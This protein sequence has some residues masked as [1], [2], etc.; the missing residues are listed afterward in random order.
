MGVGET[1]LTNHVRLTCVNEF[2]GMRC[3]TE[4]RDATKKPEEHC[5]SV[6]AVMR[7]HDCGSSYQGNHFPGAGSGLRDLVHYCSGGKHGSTWADAMLEEHHIWI[8]R[9]RKRGILGKPNPK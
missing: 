3:L 9:R 5:L 4:S 2:Q 6:L 8:H 7:H 1:A